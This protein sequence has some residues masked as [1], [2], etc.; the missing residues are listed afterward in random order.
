MTVGWAQELHS[1]AFRDQPGSRTDAGGPWASR[2]LRSAVVNGREVWYSIVDGWAV[3]DGDIV[4]GR[5]RDLEPARPDSARLKKSITGPVTRRNIDAIGIPDDPPPEG[6]LWPGGVVPYV[7][8]DTA[9]D[10]ELG[11]IRSAVAEWNAR[12]PVKLVPRTGESDFLRFVRKGDGYCRSA[13]GRKGGEQLVWAADCGVRSIVHEIGHA[14]GL[15]H[16]HQR[17]DRDAYVMVAF[18]SGSYDRSA[19][20]GEGPYD[21][22]SVMHYGGSWFQSIPPGIGIAN[23]RA[24]GFLS[25]GDID[26]VRRFYGESPEPTVVATNPSGLEV[27]VDGYRVSTPATFYWPAGSAHVLEAP[28]WQQEY[29]YGRWHDDADRVREVTASPAQTWIEAQYIRRADIEG[30]PDRVYMDQFDEFDATPCALTF[31]SDPAQESATQVIR[32]TNRGDAPATFTAFSNQTWLVVS[33]AEA[34]LGPGQTT[35]ITVGATRGSLPAASHSAELTVRPAGPE[36]SGTADLP[37]IPVAHVVLPEMTEVRLGTSGETAFVAHSATEGLLDKSGSRLADGKWVTAT[38]GSRYSL[39]TGTD[40]IVAR[41]MPQQQSVALDDRGTAVTLTNSREAIWRIGRQRV[42]SPHRLSRN[43]KEYLLELRNGIWRHARF[44]PSRMVASGFL[45]PMGLA[46]GASGHAYVADFWAHR[47]YKIDAATGARESIAGTGVRGFSGDGGT[48]TEARLA[49]PAGVVVDAAGN[50]Y[51]SD[52]GNH[53]IRM[54]NRSTGIIS[55]I[56]GTGEPGDSGNGGPALG[57]QLGTPRELAMDLMGNIYIADVQFGKIRRIEAGTGL[58][59]EFSEGS[60]ATTDAAGNVYVLGRSNLV[61]RIDATT[62]VSSTVT[63]ANGNGRV[64]GTADRTRFGHLTDVA[65]DAKGNLYL[66]DAGN[67]VVWMVQPGIGWI[68]RIATTEHRSPGQTSFLRIAVD[69]GGSIWVTDTV[70]GT[71]SVLEPSPLVPSAQSIRL[72]GGSVV[73]IAKVEGEWRIGDDLVQSGHRIPHGG[74]DMVIGQVGAEW[75]VT[76]GRVPLGAGQG[77]LEITVRGDGSLW[78]NGRPINDGSRV[79]A[80]DFSTYTVTSGSGGIAATLA[81]QSQ[82]VELDRGGSL[83]LSQEPN[84]TWRVG[85]TRVTDVNG[86]DY[87]RG[88][89]RYRLELA[90]GRWEATNQGPAYGIRSVARGIAGSEGIPA[91][92]ARLVGPRGIAVDALGN[93]FVAET[94]NRRVR[95]I[96][97][98][99]IIQTLAGT[100]EGGYSGDGGPALQARFRSARGVAVDAVGNVYVADEGDHRVRKI[101]TTGVITTVAGTGHSAFGGDGGPAMAAQ[102]SEPT[103]LAVDSAGNIY[104]ADFGNQRIRQIDRNGLISTAAGTGE[105]G[106]VGDGGMATAAQLSSPRSVAVDATGN[107]YFTEIA[108]SAKQFAWINRVRKIDAAGIISTVASGEWGPARDGVPATETRFASVEGVAADAVGNLYLA[109]RFNNRVRKIDSG[110]TISSL[111]EIESPVGLA[112]DAAGAVYVAD[113]SN[114]LV[115]KIGPS[116]AVATIAGTG[117]LT[118]ATGVP[119][120]EAW[121]VAPNDLALDPAGNPIFTDGNRVWKLDLQLMTVTAIA[122]SGVPRGSG[123]SGASLH[124]PEGLAV[125]ATGN[126]FVADTGNARVVRVD[127]AGDISTVAGTGSLEIG[128]ES[129][130]ANQVRL[131]RPTGVAV[132]TT[133]HVYVADADSHRV[134]KIDPAGIITTVAGTGV[135]GVAGGDGPPTE[136]QLNSPK[137]VAVDSSGDVYVLERLRVLKIDISTQTI[138]TVLSDS[139]DDPFTAVTADGFGRTYVAAGNQVWKIDADGSSFLVAGSGEVSF[140]GDGDRALEA[141]L[142]ISGIAVDSS[143][144]IWFSDPFNRR[145]RV[146]E[147][148]R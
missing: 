39:E 46:V 72:P 80:P 108:F 52:S 55:T 59:S 101:D 28:L 116:G 73:S 48:A 95:R 140:S 60:G 11:R 132:D 70:A 74:S 4:L 131:R 128:A 53:R 47:V 63:G 130:P 36:P 22:R 85:S 110:G 45:S 119:A 23:A 99:G 44:S 67:S 109:D 134:L 43:G 21:Y 86:F 111:A 87:R 62:L 97:S 118:A 79:T 133:G 129:V 114:H 113:T 71:V 127:S 82:T 27:V 19:S 143:G 92:R 126:V 41:F 122:G 34:S 147:P 115:W 89:W 121:I 26:G 144:D 31:I 49:R 125:D 57:S 16:E 100:G 12:T 146:L 75:R 94:T 35:D 38:N 107:L 102:L 10:A 25:L 1:P 8:E 24:D 135:R 138:A 84:G 117:K 42:S 76:S 96:N 29:V 93:V 40:G 141:G 17:A 103:G 81:P 32:L 54:I 123:E 66:A 18:Q 15:Q 105:S 65:V 14:I 30:D 9:T 2:G 106:S 139:I 136:A 148:S 58:I 78:Y 56:A 69:P 33:P 83:N 137:R 104:V 88:G 37:G 142:S 50:V 98:A 51:I 6:R 120:D 112:V 7:T 3:H 61:S 91:V 13:V 68:S 64:D 5:V 77:S 124:L 90:Q 145:I 20:R